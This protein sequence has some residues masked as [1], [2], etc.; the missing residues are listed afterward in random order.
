M[1][2]VIDQDAFFSLLFVFLHLYNYDNLKIGK[3]EETRNHTL[4]GILR[5]QSCF[6]G[7]QARCHLIELRRG[8]ATLQSCIVFTHLNFSLGH[9]FLGLFNIPVFLQ[10][11]GEK[12]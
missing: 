2:K 5:V 9:N 3:L 1:L 4:H 8:I 12:K 6:R 11:F 10:L 7:Y